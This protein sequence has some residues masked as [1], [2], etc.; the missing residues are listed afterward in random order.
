MRSDEDE[1]NEE[2]RKM[3]RENFVFHYFAP[4]TI[5]MPS[6]HPHGPLHASN[7]IKKMVQLMLYVILCRWKK[8]SPWSLSFSI[9]VMKITFLSSNILRCVD[10][11]C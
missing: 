9:R 3:V 2:D 5:V 8:K 4:V 7:F 11:W 6:D 1:L 10:Y